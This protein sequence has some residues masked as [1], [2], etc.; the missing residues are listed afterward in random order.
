[1]Y[2]SRNT[3]CAAALFCSACLAWAGCGKSETESSTAKVTTPQ[4]PS[5][6]TGE[7]GEQPKAD[8]E[9]AEAAKEPGNTHLSLQSLVHLADF[10][11]G[12]LFIDFG[13]PARPKYTVGG[14]K[15]GWGKDGKS[16]ETTFTYANSAS[17][18]VYVPLAKAEACTVRLR[19]KPIGTG[20]LQIYMNN[21]ALPSVKLDKSPEFAEYDVPVPAGATRAGENNLQL[22]FGGTTKID[23]EDIAAA[24]DWIRVLP[25]PLP[26]QVAPAT[27]YASI[28]TTAAVGGQKRKAIVLPAPASLTYYVEVPSDAKLL[29][30]FGAAEVK[31]ATSKPAVNASIRVTPDG[32]KSKEIWAAPLDSTW[33]Q[34]QLSLKSYAGNVVKLELSVSGEGSGA[35]STPTIT[36]AK[37]TTAQAKTQAKSVIVVLID[38]M[39]ADHLK[40]YNP[41][42]RV[43][44]PAL[45][46]FAASGATMDAAQAPENWT[47]PSVASVLTGLWPMLVSEAFKSAGFATAA[48]IA[49]GYV[50]DKFGFDQGWDYYTNYIRENKPT[51]AERVFKDAAEWA[52]KN[53][54]KRFFLYVHT[55]DP[56][57]P[58]DPP[59]E[60]LQMYRTE[61][62][63]GQV[64]PRLTPDQLEKAKRVPPKVKFDD[65]DR[66]Y[67][68]ALYDGEVSYHDK[69]FGAF[70]ARLNKSKLLDDTVVV[71][72][73]DHGEEF[74]DHNS[75]GH[76]HSVYQELLHVPFIV[77][78][79]KAIAQQKAE[80][81]VSTVDIA[82][83]VLSAAGV[84]VP[85]VMEG[86]DR[87]PQLLGAMP[88]G[89]SVAFSDFLDDRR[90]IRAGRWKLILSGLRATFFDLQTDPGEKV[91]LD[92]QSHPIALRYCR[93][94]IGQ[95]MGARDR[96]DWVSAVQKG[97]SP[98]FKSEGVE[99]DEHT[100]AGLKALGY[101]N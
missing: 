61:P 77:R 80:N 74:Y 56:H 86:V 51:T 37:P 89:P 79:P 60:F 49:N 16:G 12:G 63:S 67:L 78:W 41:S 5:G 62:Y 32:G 96:G 99:M 15:T 7:Q 92:L 39:R 26:A 38:T 87:M 42:T 11:R 25:S 75:Y 45:D 27:S 81:T 30:E 10:N 82:P 83:T 54:D 4:A 9:E 17:A 28:V 66:A 23:D 84:K 29:F 22:R 21:Q 46:A 88:P 50:S 40:P 90:V 19:L 48:F 97:K 31:G 100:K 71:V 6:A 52:E 8:P 93:I 55:I 85:D 57:V 68:E 18:R 44:T 36:V 33:K 24:V 76:G 13:T 59:A 58:Y 20:T 95:F 69:Y 35:F 64:K 1:M 65:D 3:V 14:W 70:I 73:A 53:R 91:E 43:Q 72:T 101:A 98:D 94:L 47:K 34:Q 2:M